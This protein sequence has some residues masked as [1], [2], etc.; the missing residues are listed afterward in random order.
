[1][2]PI[3]N[4][5]VYWS[6]WAAMIPILLHL[7]HKHMFIELSNAKDQLPNRISA[8]VWN[9]YGRKRSQAQ[10]IAPAFA[11]VLAFRQRYTTEL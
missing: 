4:E 8:G 10:I 7:F 5:S 2:W 6:W 9:A 3:K 11:F 1:M